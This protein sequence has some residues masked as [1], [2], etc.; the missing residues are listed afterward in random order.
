[1]TQQ[2]FLK[3]ITDVFKSYG[4]QKKGNNFY[5][6][7]GNDILGV[8]GLQKSNYGPDYYVEYGYAF[9]S[10]NAHAPFPKYYQMNLSLG[11]MMFDLNKKPSRTVSFEDLTDAGLL[12]TME[13]TLPLFCNA[14]KMGKDEIV[15]SY[16]MSQ[17]AYF[18]GKSTPDYLGLKGD[19]FKILP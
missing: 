10:I 19:N 18:R 4:F 7:F 12:L 6:D 9:L 2:E 3:K 1:M 14:G 15:R 17:I 13:R 5:R 11:R 16:P 8:I